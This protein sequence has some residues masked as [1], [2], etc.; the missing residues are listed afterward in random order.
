MENPEISEFGYILLFIA[1]GFLF[2]LFAMTFS[3]LLSP[4]KPGYE[5]NLSYECGEDAVGNQWAQFNSRFY[6][7]AL[8][9]LLF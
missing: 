7:I 6:I 2:V 5:K 3:K 8:I 9:F 4:S 1:G